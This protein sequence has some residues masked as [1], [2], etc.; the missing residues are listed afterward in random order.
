V[1]AYTTYPTA[2]RGVRLATLAVAL[3]LALVLAPVGSAAAAKCTKT[4]TGGVDVLKGTKK[5]DVLCGKGG[6]D[7]LIGKGGDDVLKAGPGADI[8]SGKSGN[9]TLAGGPGDDSLSG[10]KGNDNYDGQDGVDVAAFADLPGPV[11]VDLA[12]GTASG[13]GEDALSG[14]E[15]VIG[16]SFADSLTGDA[17]DNELSG[18]DGD[19]T[20]LGGAGDDTLRGQ[21]GVDSTSYAAAAGPVVADLRAG[22]VTGIGTDSISG[23]ENLTGS[24]HD[25]AIAGD[26]ADNVLDAGGGVDTISFAGAPNGVDADLAGGQASGDGNDALAGFENLIGSAHDDTLNGDGDANVVDGAG[27]ADTLTTNDGDDTLTGGD[28]IDSLNGGDGSDL[29]DGGDGADTLSG[30][31]GNDTLSGDDGNDYLAGNAGDDRI[32]GAD[33]AD[34]LTGDPGGDTLT[35]GDGA[36]SLAGGEGAD[37]IDGSDGADTLAGDG[38]DDNLAGGPGS[39]TL[40]YAGSPTAVNADLRAGSVSGQGADLVAGIEDLIATDQ[41][42][43]L[44]GDA[45][46]NLLDARGGT[47]TVSFADSPAAVD[48]NLVSGQATG[49]GEDVLLAVE[50]V[51]GSSGD[52]SIT[53]DD[54]ANAIAGGPGD[55]AISA[56]DGADHIS[57]QAGDDRLFGDQGD[58]DLFGGPDDDHL[59]GGN[60]FNNCD[61]GTGVNTFAGNCDAAPPVLQALAIS[62]PSVDTSALARS[63]GFT[64]TVT[65]DASGVDPAAS[66]VTVIGPSGVPTFESPLQFVTGNPLN[67]SYSASVVLPRY[68]PQ[69]TWTV[70]V[71]LA[72]EA[73][74][75]LALTSANLNTAGL[76]HDFQQTGVG[77]L[78]GPSLSGFDLSPTSIDTFAAAAV[79]NFDVDAG[80]DLSGVDPAASRVIVHGPSG[81]PTYEGTLALVAGDELNGSYTAAVT[82]PRY[83]ATGTWT[84]E[85][86][87]A[88]NAGYVTS[89]SSTQL[90]AAGD[91]GGFEQTGVGDSDTPDL[92]AFDLTPDTINTEQGNDT[93]SFTLSG[94]DAL[95]GIDA[96]ASSIVVYDPVNQPQFVVPI[97]AAGGGYAGSI[98]LPGGSAAGVWT[99]EVHL[100]DVAGNELVVTSA[101]LIA[102]GFPGSFDNVAPSGT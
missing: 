49:D 83:S 88:D 14:V 96:A 84:V 10:G 71:L 3:F 89:V 44:A 16:T 53:A 61:G 9:D 62:P 91:P 37:V 15:N 69:G 102:A 55:D 46:A 63:V 36:D 48:V 52:D 81:A 57:G 97:S 58:D 82:I 86:R 2:A 29:V 68:S 78:G 70:Q 27:G 32:D 75:Q 24:A 64:L 13:D 85:L 5:K 101:E 28:G 1:T 99:V 90:I 42:D 11:A 92:T 20:L 39:D 43:T 50:N 7:V 72:D 23:I 47:D 25:D 73:G 93:I 45:G 94:A 12:A 74:N 17:A 19:D 98:T 100:V 21:G 33:G 54:Q 59:D 40:T 31:D 41:S 30:D 4:G 38:G 22:T 34:T 60:G 51:I 8:V 6:D 66:R 80:D 77:D 56:A 26:D 95:S 18:G 35:G 65:D 76:P 87:L 79:V 67:G